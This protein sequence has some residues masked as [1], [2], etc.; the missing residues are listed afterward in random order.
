MHSVDLCAVVANNA[1]SFFRKYLFRQ[2]PLI[3]YKPPGIWL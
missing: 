1:K 3:Y 2:T